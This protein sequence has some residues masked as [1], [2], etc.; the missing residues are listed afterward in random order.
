MAKRTHKNCKHLFDLLEA[1]DL[2]A[3][4]RLGE[5]APFEFLAAID[6]TL[7]GPAFRDAAGKRLS[8]LP[9]DAVVKADQQAVR[10]LPL[11]DWRGE[12]LLTFAES[13]WVFK[14]STQEDYDPQR[15][16][17]TRLIWFWARLPTVFDQIETVYLAHH[18]HGH[19][20]FKPFKIKDGD[21]RPFVWNE[22]IEAQLQTQIGEVLALEDEGR[23]NCEIIHFEMEDLDE[24]DGGTTRPLHY[25]VV[26]HPGKMK[27]LRQMKDRRRD[28]L[29]FFP[30]LEATLV[31]DPAENKIMVLADKLATRLALAECFAEIGFES[32]L[33][34]E[35]LEELNYELAHF[36]Q[37]VDLLQPK[38]QGCRIF[39]AWVSA[40]ALSLGHSSHRI[41]VT[42]GDNADI[43]TVLDEQFG[44]NNPLTQARSIYEIKLCFELRFDD[45]EVT[46]PLDMSITYRTCSLWSLKDPKLRA[47]GE[48]IL[49]GLG[50]MHRVDTVP[51]PANLSQFMAELQLLDQPESS[52]EGFL[53]RE[54]MLDVPALESQGLLRKQALG[55]HITRLIE[56]DEGGLSYQRLD[57]RQNSLRTWAVDP[58]TH[59]EIDLTESDLRRYAIH[60]PWLRER[61]GHQLSDQLTGVPNEPDA[62]EPFFLGFY[63]FG[64][65]ALPIH[66]VTC[67]WQ[68]RQVTAIDTELRKLGM[69]VGAVLTTTTRHHPPF[70]GSSRVVPLTELI[71]DMSPDRLLDLS[72]IEPEIRRWFHLGETVEQPQ[73]LLEPGGAVLIGPWPTPWT[74][75]KPEQIAIVRILVKAW[76]SGK[77]KC[78]NDEVLADYE[79]V[80]RLPERFRGSDE[81]KTYI[82][83]AEDKQRSRFWELNIGQPSYALE[84]SAS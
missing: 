14:Q 35:P 10:I 74:L 65:Q 31:Y 54:L 38:L 64:D 69:G 80:R 12:D 45:E 49:V 33:S 39:K 13:T 7:D 67:L 26:Y 77:R 1:A 20:K 82:R 76:I 44:A 29:A 24:A 78:S 28:L 3:L 27:T 59:T 57:V 60:K 83:S 62:K 41:L 47:I 21:H 11:A 51:V 23:R 63:S 84:N 5:M 73:L 18:Y 22:T 17:L 81:W 42:L 19:K 25:V 50:L 4:H 61:I 9:R 43:W 32:P 53:L 58:L 72:R 66:L 79:G 75:T 68:D 15:D 46:R 48:D 37:P 70:L 16:M 55:N 52:V 8:E 36:Q 30:A 56:D 40:M 34:A 2:P 6:T 71:D